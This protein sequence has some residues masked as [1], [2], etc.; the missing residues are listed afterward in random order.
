M[1]PGTVLF[2]EATLLLL[3]LLLVPAL[4]VFGASASPVWPAFLSF[5]FEA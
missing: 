5:H 4:A 3:H 2:L 1:V